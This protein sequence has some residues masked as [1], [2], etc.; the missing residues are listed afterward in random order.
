MSSLI[1]YTIFNITSY[2]GAMETAKTLANLTAKTVVNLT[3]KTVVNLKRYHLP[4]VYNTTTNS[5]FINATTNGTDYEKQ[6][7]ALSLLSIPA[8]TLFGNMLV[9]TSVW[10]YHHL[11]SPINYFILGLAVADLLVAIAVMPL[12]VY[13]EVSDIH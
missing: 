12:A 13:V 8:V 2:A 1:L 6:Y 9:I 7:W 11:K 3:A 4:L 10:R 5:Y